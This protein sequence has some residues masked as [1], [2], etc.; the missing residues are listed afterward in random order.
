[1]TAP[2]LFGSVRKLAMLFQPTKGTEPIPSGLVLKKGRKGGL[3]NQFIGMMTLVSHPVPL[4]GPVGF[5][6]SALLLISV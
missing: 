1:M 4:N 5:R 2:I 6:S 3:L